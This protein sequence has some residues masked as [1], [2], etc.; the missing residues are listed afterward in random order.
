MV[1]DHNFN[2]PTIFQSGKSREIVGVGF[3]SRV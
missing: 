2:L 1:F 3:A